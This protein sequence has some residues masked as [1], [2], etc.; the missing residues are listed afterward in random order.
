M[1]RW[2]A[3]EKKWRAIRI[4]GQT[5]MIASKHST[6]TE[7]KGHATKKIFSTIPDYRIISA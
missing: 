4:E 6:I 5:D 1:V 2:R 3:R 7:G